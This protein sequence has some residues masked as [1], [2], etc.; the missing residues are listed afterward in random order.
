M[1]IAIHRLGIEPDLAQ[2]LGD[3]LAALIRGHPLALNDQAF[4]D[5]LED[6]EPRRQ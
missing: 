2:G 5:D 3:A 4:L 6:R 1:R